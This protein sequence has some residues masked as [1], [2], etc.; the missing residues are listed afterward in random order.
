M[1]ILLVKPINQTP[2]LLA[3]QTFILLNFQNLGI[4]SL[5]KLKSKRLCSK[6]W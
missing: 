1:V 2:K 6:S 5:L 3:N 4:R